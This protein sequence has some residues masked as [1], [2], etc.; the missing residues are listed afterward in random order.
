MDWFE[1]IYR[2]SLVG[3][4]FV[5]IWYAYETRKIRKINAEQRDLEILPAM[6]FYIRRRSGGERL[7]I[8]NIGAGTAFDVRVMSASSVVRDQTFRFDFHLTDA[9]N[10]LE[11]NE[12]REVG[13]NFWIDDKQDE[14]PRDNFLVYYNPSNL[15]DI[16]IHREGGTIDPDTEIQR[17]LEV[18]F[19]AI[20]GE[21]YVTSISFS[22]Q[23]ISVTKL[24][25]RK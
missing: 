1:L 6:M 14:R 21:E 10:S 11:P 16:K 3:T 2:L 15:H 18:R 24:P 19:K 22:D 4:F 7:F 12:E 9:N 13:V 17:T 20:T 25:K 5:L 23:G 8:R